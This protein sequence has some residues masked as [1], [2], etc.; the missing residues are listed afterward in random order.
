MAEDPPQSWPEDEPQAEG[1]S[2]QPHG[3]GP[4]LWRRHVRHVG[5]GDGVVRRREAGEGAGE[6]EHG[7]R[8]GEGEEQV[9]G[10]AAGDR[11]EQHRP[12]AHPVGEAPQERREEELGEAVGGEEQADLDRR[13][14]EPLGIE[15]QQR[16]DHPEADEVQEDGQEDR[17]LSSPAHRSAWGVHK[18]GSVAALGSQV[19]RSPSASRLKA[20]MVR[21]RAAPGKVA[22]HQA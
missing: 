19:S 4:L 12:P 9:G 10:H 7:I 17:E 6:K 18:G 21:A 8:R 14:V 11:G 15:R 2:H 1:R 5:L 13:D 16:E 3:L 22:T 20:M